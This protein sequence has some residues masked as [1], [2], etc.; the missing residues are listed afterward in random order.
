M[1]DQCAQFC[2]S[3]AQVVSSC[4]CDSE[5]GIVQVGCADEDKTTDRAT[6]TTLVVS[7]AHVLVERYGLFVIYS[8]AVSLLLL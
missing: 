7:S 5:S 6:T 2:L 3:F 8:F 4:E 1:D